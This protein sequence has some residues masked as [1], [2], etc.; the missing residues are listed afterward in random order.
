MERETGKQS[1]LVYVPIDRSLT[2][3]NDPYKSKGIHQKFN[4]CYYVIYVSNKSNYEG[5]A[6]W[7]PYIFLHHTF[8]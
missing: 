2:Y 1:S 6:T 4:F 7:C 8:T 5:T 3:S